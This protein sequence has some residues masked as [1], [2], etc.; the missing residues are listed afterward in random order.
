M[1]SSHPANLALRVVLAT[2]LCASQSFAQGVESAVVRITAKEGDRSKTGSGFVVRLTPE[3]AYIVTA[4][5]VVEGDEAPQVEFYTKRDQPVAATVKAAEV[6]DPKG[7]ALLVVSG[8][9]AIAPSLSALAL[10]ASLQLQGGDEVT[11]IGFPRMGG[12]WAVSKGH[13]SARQGRELIFVMPVG[14]G[15]SGG[16]LLM[17]GKVVA[18]VTSEAQGRAFA[19]PAASVKLFLEGSGVTG[20]ASTSAAVPVGAP[21]RSA[22][23][24]PAPST[25]AGAAAV[26]VEQALALMGASQDEATRFTVLR[27]LVRKRSLAGPVS[28]AEMLSIMQGFGDKNRVA[29]IDTMKNLLVPNL[30]GADALALMGEN[31]QESARFR[32]LQSLL[33]AGRL[34]R[35]IAGEEAVALLARFHDNL[36]IS[37]IS[38]IDKQLAA[39]LG[40]RQVLALMGPEEKEPVRHRVLLTLLRAQRIKS[41]LE[42]DEKLQLVETMTGTYRSSALQALK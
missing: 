26:S 40:V 4:S 27:D 37:A 30:S 34:Q 32:I 2:W 6:G 5:H 25:A 41:P 22:S 18:L 11:A 17:N 21:P 24:K 39:G 31:T 15:N 1:H 28:A 14:E 42:A 9:D 36:R 10:D 23:A 16:P 12:D 8:K 3:L 13:M 33:Q 19:A 35:P 29:A 38:I 20:S 7:L